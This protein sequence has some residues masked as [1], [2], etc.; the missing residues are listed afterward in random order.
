MPTMRLFTAIE[1]SDSARRHLV[2][3]QDSIRLIA[4]DGVSWTRHEN[5]HLTLKFIGEVPDDRVDALCGALEE[6]E[7]PLLR[8]RSAEVVLFPPR[9]PVRIIASGFAGD[10][11]GARLLEEQI[12]S[13]C[14]RQGIARERRQYVPHVTLARARHPLGASKRQ[15]LLRVEIS[16]GPEFETRRFVLMQSHLDSAGARYSVV[17][18]FGQ[19]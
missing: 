13:Q 3:V 1:L 4:R 19:T 8:L 10:V 14:E 5:L 17:A 9:G 7:V 12:E 15:E 18:R 6:I 2:D 11:E 16:P